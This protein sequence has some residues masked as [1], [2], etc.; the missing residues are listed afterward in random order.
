MKLTRQVILSVAPHA[1]LAI[2]DEFVKNLP[3]LGPKYGL[4]IDDEQL[5]FLAQC[6]HESN[7]LT[8]FVEN[9]NYSTPE[10]IASVWPSR[11][12]VASAKPY[13]RNP[14]G[15]ANK[16]YANRMGNGDEASGDGYR[17]RGQGSLQATGKD[18]FRKIGA[19]LGVDLI[20]RP[21]LI[22]S[23]QY[24]LL[25]AL[26]IANILGLGAIHDFKNDTHTLNGGYT[27]YA[28]RLSIYNRLKTLTT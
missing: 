28:D 4:M 14:K 17:Y 2:T 13:A 9:L 7:G 21:E 8:V 22:Q 3:L 1:N 5:Q 20:A 15:L 10:R 11:F 26:A 16:V 25:G 27:G 24:N 19:I 6:V 12:T 23:P 18:M